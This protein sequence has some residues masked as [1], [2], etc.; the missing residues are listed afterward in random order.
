[1]SRAIIRDHPSIGMIEWQA[2]PSILSSDGKVF[3]FPTKK[4]AG[5]QFYY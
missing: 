5:L 4:V 1:V 2:D 3:A